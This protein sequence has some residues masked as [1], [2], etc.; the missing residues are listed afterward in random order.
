MLLLKTPTLSLPAEHAVTVAS[1]TV[2]T[3]PVAAG[4]LLTVTDIAG[5]QPAALF[6]V[7][8]A[9]HRHFVSPHHTRVFSNS[10][11]LRLGMRVMTNRRRPAMVLGR[12]S[13][14][15]H[16]LMMPVTEAGDGSA[17]IGAAD[18]FR[19][20]VRAAFARSRVDL[21]KVPDPINLFL[22]VAVND[23][24]SLTPRGVGSPPGGAVTFRV[25]TDLV[26]GIAAPLPDHLLWTKPA[27]TAL[28]V[29]VHNFPPEQRSLQ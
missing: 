1:G 21:V 12:D 14:G 26:V 8:V 22:D 4:Q 5:G 9:D 3:F 6:A 7:A 28:A 15:T 23:E 17:Y 29:S 27:A 24:G 18:R 11:M 20:K 2:E 13:V 19:D 10:F 16:D 25:V